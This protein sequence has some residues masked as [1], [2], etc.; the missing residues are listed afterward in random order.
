[1]G[2]LVQN[3]WEYYFLFT[4]W[5]TQAD[6]E[7]HSLSWGWRYVFKEPRM[8]TS[9]C[10][11]NGDLISTAILEG[12]SCFDIPLSEEPNLGMWNIDAWPKVCH[13]YQ[14]IETLHH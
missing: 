14:F 7:D 13:N 4:G 11:I 1:M 8:I 6:Y 10:A 3:R 5:Q 9:M 12:V 2:A